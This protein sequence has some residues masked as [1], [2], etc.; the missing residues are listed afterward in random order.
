MRAPRIA[1]MVTPGS[2][3]LAS[4]P[5]GPLA[6]TCCYPAGYGVNRAGDGGAYRQDAPQDS[7]ERLAQLL[8]F[9]LN[10]TIT[11]RSRPS[12]RAVT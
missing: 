7:A 2:V 12:S 6:V 5:F 4:G 3:L 10:R 1:G 9:D 11:F 8:A